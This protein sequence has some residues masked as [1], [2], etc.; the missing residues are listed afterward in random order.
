ML[1]NNAEIENLQNKINATNTLMEKIYKQKLVLR[2]VL[3]VAPILLTLTT[4]LFFKI[5]TI[6]F[7]QTNLLLMFIACINAMLL[8]QQTSQIDKK[9]RSLLFIV[10]N[11]LKKKEKE[12]IDYLSKESVQL[13][14]LNFK[15]FDLLDSEI[16]T[17]LKK[18]LALKNFNNAYHIL[19]DMF[20]DLNKIEEQ[21][22]IDKETK[23]LISAYELE[24]KMKL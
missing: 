8:I 10:P 20:G 7:I 9:S 24:L 12:V 23:K 11:Q 18:E 15:K 16:K 3:I 19:V 13:E 17:S 1:K 6:P 14:L 5:G 21:K 2:V 22:N 4:Q